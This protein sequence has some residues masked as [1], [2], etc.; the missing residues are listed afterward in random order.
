MKLLYCIPVFVILILRESLSSPVDLSSNNEIEDFLENPKYQKYDELTDLF[1]QLQKQYPNLAKL[2]SVG[3]SV[4]NRE[5]WAL[6]INANV[7]KE[8]SQLTPMFKY[9]ANMHGDESI[10]R[11]LTI[12]MAQYLLANYGKN[13]RVTKLVN[14]TDIFLMPSMNPDGFENSEEGMCESKERYVGRQN[15]NNVD[16]NRDFPDQFD[17]IRIGTILSGR[18]PETI[19]LM[20]W[21]ISRPFVLSGNL[22]GG[23]VVASY[24]YDDS[25]ARRTCCKESASPDNELF[26]QLALTYA[27]PHAPMSQG[28]AC[29]HDKFKDGITNGALWY[30]VRG[31]MQDFNYVHSNCFE[32]TFELSCCKFPLAKVLPREWHLNKESMISFIESVHWGAKGL[33][34]DKSK[35]PILDADVVVIGINHNVTTSNRGEYWRLLLPGEYQMFATAY[36]YEPSKPITVTVSKD[37]TTVQHFILERAVPTKGGAYEEIVNLTRPMFDQYGFMIDPGLEFHHHNYTDMERFLLEYNSTYPNITDLKVIGKSVQGRN[38][39]VFVLGNTP[40][41]HVPGKPEFKYVANM[42]GNEVVGR[43]MLLLLIKFLCE[44]YMS[45]DRITKMLNTTRI[46][47][48]P[49][50]NPDGYEMSHE[51]DSDST[52]GRSNANNVDLNRNFPDQYVINNFNKVTEPETKAMMDWILSEPFVLSANLHNGALVANYPYDDNPDSNEYIGQANPSPDDNVFKNLAHTYSDAHRKMHLGKPCPLFPKEH[53]EGGITN[54]AKWY[55]VT[56]GMQ[57][58]N[59]LVAGCMEITLELGCY[60]FPKAAQL[61]NYWL[62]N[63]DALLSYIEQ[64]HRGVKGFVFSTIGRGIPNAEVYVEGN[65]HAVRTAKTGDYYRILLPGTYNLTVAARGYESDTQTIVVPENGGQIQVNFTLM[66][67]DPIHWASAY[68]FGITENQY[69][70]EYH[71]NSDIYKLLAQLE[72]RYP[73]SAQFEGGEDY[74]SMTIHSLKI[75]DKID[76]SDETKFQVAVIGN[77]FATQPIGREISVYLARHLLQGYKFGDPNIVSILEN[78]V[79]TIIPVI[80]VAFEKIWGDYPKFASGINKPDKFIC[81]NIS[82]DFR[83]VGKELMGDGIRSGNPQANIVNAFKHLLLDKKFD[84]MLNFEG[85]R[86]GFVYPKSRGPLNVHEKFAQTYLNALKYTQGCENN[87]AATDGNLTE[88]IASEYGTAM[89]TAKVSCCQYPSIENIPFIWR[90]VITPAIKFLS[91]TRTGVEGTILDSQNRLLTNATVRVEGINV[92]HQVTP[93]LAHFKIMLPPGHYILE[94]SNGFEYR[95]KMLKVD[96]IEYKMSNCNVTLMMKNGEI[97]KI[98]ESTTRTILDSD[99][100]VIEE[101][102]PGGGFGIAGA[103]IVGFVRDNLNHPIPNAQIL[104]NDKNLNISSDTN[105]RY[106]LKV[107]PGQYTFKVVADGYEP[108]V[109]FTTI[110]EKQ[111]SLVVFTLVRNEHV[112]GMPRSVFII[113]IVL[114]MMIIGGIIFCCCKCKNDKEYGLLPQN[115]NEEFDHVMKDYNKPITRPYFDDDDDDHSDIDNS[116]EESSEDDI[117]LLNRKDSW[118]KTHLIK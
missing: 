97:K 89:F 96:V 57:D 11:Q 12:Y 80:D 54:G 68:D 73:S 44:N 74:I 46:H 37:Q 94:I 3:R 118:S 84:M 34:T 55:S 28:E 17:P 95:P 45:N 26:K 92:L 88:F 83:E 6:E 103:G 36:G 78:T 107:A 98:S 61:P 47:I 64:V 13:E 86:G 76:S 18:Q 77:L 39:Y 1:K 58:W 106:M 27:K 69:K 24:P 72:T 42:H 15:E 85:G 62:D 81:N 19:S 71:S 50:M 117:V 93:R 10:G 23:A 9:V 51:G 2:I 7:Q 5:L 65:N 8:R 30:E 99:G 4:K 33:V 66:R 49:S 32:V 112:W 82:A 14:S 101:I 105:G 79:I 25:A 116:Q 59:Y 48:M 63:H 114:I 67:D 38:L 52:I 16:L 111:P 53:F 35:E 60:K 100:N 40:T 104:M 31:G 21:I 43:E 20:T 108:M 41:K 87:I 115:P 109:K 22:H 90:E 91:Q 110:D 75:T 70:P 29:P 113:F 102:V 56:G